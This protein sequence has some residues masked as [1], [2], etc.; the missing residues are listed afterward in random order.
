[1]VFS[2]AWCFIF[3][4]GM[5]ESFY[6]IF[7]SVK[8]MVDMEDLDSLN[9]EGFGFFKLPYFSDIFPYVQGYLRVWILLTI[10]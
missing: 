5:C 9:Y 8:K 4:L 2:R 10:I 7:V 3:V 6:I 1:M